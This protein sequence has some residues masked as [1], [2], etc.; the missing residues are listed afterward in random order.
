MSVRFPAFCPKC[1]LIFPT[2][3]LDIRGDTTVIMEDNV[4]T[5]PRCGAWAELP[6]GSF[7]IV[8]DTIRVLSASQ[9]T[10][11][12][13][14]RL[15]AILEQAQAGKLSEDEAA[16]RVVDVAPAM[17]ELWDR[18]RPRMG[19]AL[20]WF[21]GTVIAVLISQGVSEFR[22][23]SATKADVRNAV[24]EAISRCQAE[25]PGGGRQGRR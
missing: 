9:L 11:E 16:A 23:N 19:K 14:F 7:S 3:A 12:R 22:D 8:D 15:A 24:E 2:R 1:G 13:L 18:L 25:W 6:D 5:C 10:R 17:G 4:E 21:I 20:I